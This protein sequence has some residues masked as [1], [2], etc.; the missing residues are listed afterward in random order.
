VRPRVFFGVSDEG[1][2]HDRI[3]VAAADCEQPLTQLFIMRYLAPLPVLDAGFPGTP[4][5]H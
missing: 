3:V 1:D 4:S 5:L 2:L